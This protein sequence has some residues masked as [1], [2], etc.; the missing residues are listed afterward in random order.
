[1]SELCETE[2]DRIQ[3]AASL[4]ARAEHET[5]NAVACCLLIEAAELLRM[6]AL[7]LRTTLRRIERECASSDEMREVLHER[8]P[9]L[10]E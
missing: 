4:M 2:R 5:D 10:F 8:E 1:M 7:H 3:R 6:E 9:W